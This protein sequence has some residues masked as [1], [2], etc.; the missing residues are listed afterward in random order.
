MESSLLQFDADGRLIIPEAIKADL[1]KQRP[2]K[3]VKMKEIPVDPFN[4]NHEIQ[5]DEYFECICMRV[6]MLDEAIY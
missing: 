3:I 6:Q 1:A 4:L 5:D 2:T